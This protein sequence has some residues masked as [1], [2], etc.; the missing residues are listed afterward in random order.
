[1][2]IMV[3]LSDGTAAIMETDDDPDDYPVM[4][5]IRAMAYALMQGSQIRLW[6]TW[7][8]TPPKSA[9]ET[10]EESYGK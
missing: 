2:K 10:E 9:A 1:M 8:D 7:T 3:V 5:V 4:M 6:H